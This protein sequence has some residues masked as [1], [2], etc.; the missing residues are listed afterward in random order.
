MS[1]TRIE[2]PGL[3]LGNG[4]IERY[5]EFFDTR[6]HRH[7]LRVVEKLLQNVG[8]EG[9]VLDIGSGVGV[10][11]ILLCDKTGYF[12]VY[13]LERSSLL[14]RSG[15]AITSRLGYGR[16]I[17]LKIWENDT[18]PF[19]DG[20]FDAVVSVFSLHKWGDCQ[21]IFREIERVRKSKS[22]VFITDFRRGLTFPPFFLFA[23]RSR[24]A[25]GKDIASDLLNSYKASYTPAEVEPILNDAGLQGWQIEKDGR[26]LTI[27]SPLVTMPT[28]GIGGE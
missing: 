10:F 3:V 5:Y 22:V 18:L 11:G 1:K 19:P 16:R 6:M 15:E 13:G 4:D 20:E 7:Y 24:L 2:Y 14:V 23:L 17:S 27:S 12:N 28:A 21:K 25:A 9:K 26:L 8:E